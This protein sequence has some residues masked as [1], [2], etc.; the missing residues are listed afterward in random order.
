MSAKKIKNLINSSLP[1]IFSSEKYYIK[2]IEYL[3]NSFHIHKENPVITDIID[4]LAHAKGFGGGHFHR[5]ADGRHSITGAFES[6]QDDFPE[7]PILEKIS[8]VFSHLLSD[9]NSISG[10]PLYSFNNYESFKSFCDSLSLSPKLVQDLFSV[11]STEF[12]GSALSIIPILFN[13]NQMES[14]EFAKVASRLGILTTMGQG[15]FELISGTFSLILLAK[16][17]SS[18]KN[19]GIPY[20]KIFQDLWIEGSFTAVSLASTQLLPI[21]VGLIIPFLIIGLKNNA[22]EHGLQK[23][24]ELFGDHLQEQYKNIST[25]ITKIDINSHMNHL[26]EWLNHLKLADLKSL[27]EIQFLLIKK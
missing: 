9:F 7:L 25:Q 16:S 26:F 27:I 23:S 8:G 19:E 22:H 21:P 5:I 2:V 24:F 4:K 14:S 1:I 10:I 6:I 11:N 13:F 17:F 20:S 18:A 12:I 3:D 15:Q